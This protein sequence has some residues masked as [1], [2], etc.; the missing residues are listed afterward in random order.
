MR[1]GR[2]SQ[3]EHPEGRLCPQWRLAMMMSRWFS[4]KEKKCRCIIMTVYYLRL[5]V[6][7]ET[8]PTDGG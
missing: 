1:S 3:R 4:V 8:W 5:R 2:W 7:A 6:Y